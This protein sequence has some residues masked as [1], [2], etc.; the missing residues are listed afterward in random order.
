MGM[1]LMV[2]LR[3]GDG[4]NLGYWNWDEGAE[5]VFR[6]SLQYNQ[7]NLGIVPQLKVGKYRVDFGVFYGVGSEIR[8]IAIECDGH[9]FHERTKAQAQRDKSRD[10]VLQARAIPVFRFTGSEIYANSP[11]L[12]DSVGSFLWA[13]INGLEGEND[14]A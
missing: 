9:D 13:Q 4:L 6:G 10:R 3:S 11:N 12:L 1:R 7:T 8:R 2:L 14:A 5:L